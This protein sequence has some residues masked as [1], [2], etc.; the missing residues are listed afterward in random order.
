MANKQNKIITFVLVALLVVSVFFLQSSLAYFSDVDNVNSNEINVPFVSNKV[1]KAN[2]LQVNLVDGEIDSYMLTASENTTYNITTSIT[3]NYPAFLR[4]NV[5]SSFETTMASSWSVAKNIYNVNYDENNFVTTYDDFY[6]YTAIIPA[7]TA[8]DISICS[9]TAD[10]EDDVYIDVQ[11]IQA[12]AYGLCNMWNETTEGEPNLEIRTSE[13]LFV[14]GNSTLISKADN[15]VYSITASSGDVLQLRFTFPF[16]HTF[17]CNEATSN[18][19]LSIT[20]TESK[21]IN[22]TLNV[23]D[24][25]DINYQIVVTIN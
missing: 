2:D 19:D 9:F 7:N 13:T 18:A 6:Y 22:V 11:L 17:I 5:F 1:V 23:L 8:T 25:F 4:V 12:N 24:T 15:N 10:F 14:L 3:S 21:T 20:L 16:A